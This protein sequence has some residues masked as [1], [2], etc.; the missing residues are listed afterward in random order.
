MDFIL[1]AAS[2]YWDGSLDVSTVALWQQ[3]PCFRSRVGMGWL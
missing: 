2:L 3:G 1:F